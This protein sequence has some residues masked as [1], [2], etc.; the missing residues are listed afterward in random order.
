MGTFRQNLRHAFG[1]DPPE[2]RGSQI[3]PEPLQRFAQT[4]VDKGMEIPAILFLETVRPLNF[5]AGQAMQ[6]AGP[7]VQWSIRAEDYQ[8]VA[9]ALEDRQTISALVSLIEQLSNSPGADQ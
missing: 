1:L 6:A 7:L 5:L 4:V 8:A 2:S 3:L 9:H